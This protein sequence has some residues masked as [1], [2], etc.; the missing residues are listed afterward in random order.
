MFPV[1][2]LGTL[3]MFFFSL[4]GAVIVGL[5]VL[6]Y[7]A[8]S[9]LVIVE[10]TAA[11]G[12]FVRWPDEPLMDWLWKPFYLAWVWAGPIVLVW[13]GLTVGAPELLHD[14]VWGLLMAGGSL[15]LLFPICLLSSL[16][17]RTRLWLVHPGLLARLARYPVSLLLFYLLSSAVLAAGGYL[18]YLGL[19][20][21]RWEVLA[22][23]VPAAVGLFFI[24]ARL[25]GRM[26]WLVGFRTPAKNK[27][28]KKRPRALESNDPWSVPD[29]EPE[30]R[31]APA[32]AAGE[33]TGSSEQI[34][35]GDP[36]GIGQATSGNPQADM[37]E[38][39]DEWTPNKKPYAVM[40]DDAPYPHQEKSVHVTR[41]SSAEEDPSSLQEAITAHPPLPAPAIAAAPPPEV[42][43]PIHRM[44]PVD[45]R[46]LR[47]RDPPPPRYPL[48]S[49]VWTFPIYDTSLRPLINLS[50]T[51]LLFAFLLR[52]VLQFW[53][54]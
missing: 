14:P 31:G 11:G 19:F 25:L 3:L 50:L 35:A 32:A 44:F 46:Y 4:V 10:D 27:G 34:A 20:G 39:E 48:F 13:L 16:S 17:G 8:H 29:E 43:E 45:P 30:E 12:D 36:R 54:F 28:K 7:A 53:P 23:A 6:S 52:L 51:G 26:G 1:G 41:A 2:A 22:V 47:P 33:Q 24:H 38:E 21:T 37:D 49:G 40:K 18:G 9:Y 42:A 5:M 15:W